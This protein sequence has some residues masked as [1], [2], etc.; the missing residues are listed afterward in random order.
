METAA[1]SSEILRIEL[2]RVEQENIKLNNR[3]VSLTKEIN[4]SRSSFKADLES[5]KNQITLLKE[6]NNQLQRVI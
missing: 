5:A 6:E 2:E 3:I 1:N 4:D